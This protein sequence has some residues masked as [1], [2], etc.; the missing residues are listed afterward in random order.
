MK[1]VLL[2]LLFLLGFILLSQAQ[3]DLTFNSL[4]SLF[5]YADNNSYVMKTNDKNAILAKFQKVAS[6]ANVI[7]FRDP[8]TF[9]MN[10]NTKLPASFVPGGTV[11]PGTIPGTYVKLTLG[12]QYVSN[13]NIMPQIDIINAGNWAQIQSSDINVKVIA[14]QNL[15]NKK[16]L[17]ESIAACYFNIISFN[18]Q[19]EITKQNMTATDSLLVIVTNK[20]N[21]GQVSQKNVNDATINKYVL[22][23][24]FN[25]LIFSIDQQYNSLKILCDIPPTTTISISDALNYNQQ[26]NTGITAGSQLLFRYNLLQMEY[27]KANLKYNRLSNLPVLSLLYSNSFYQN[28]NTQFFDRSSNPS[29]HWLNAVY[30]GP[31]VT[32]NLPDVNRLISTRNA[33]INY[34]IARINFEHNKLQNDLNNKQVVLDY[35]KAFSQCTMYKQVFLLKLD[36]YKIA[37]N[38]YNQSIIAFDALL[39]SF[40]DMVVSKLNYCSALANMNYSK[41]KIDINNNIK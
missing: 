32:F 22:Q 14:T 36:N 38:Q 34:Q 40:N 31:R 15:L 16:S 41:S 19:I 8:V 33:K 30:F 2:S 18:E 9:T 7:N 10:D 29:F 13:L 17:H 35:E 25:Q 6:I 24:K 28:S 26:F 21:Q 12:L 11:I 1:T 23:D 39:N 5:S 27:A 20:F 3:T 37:T 4:D